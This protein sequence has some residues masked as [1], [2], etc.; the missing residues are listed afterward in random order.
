V[1]RIGIP[2]QLIG[3]VG[4]SGTPFALG[5]SYKGKVAESGKLYLRIGPSPWNCE[6]TGSYKVT[7]NVTTP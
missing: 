1:Q 4:P 6:S 2:G 5:A 7:V 3:R